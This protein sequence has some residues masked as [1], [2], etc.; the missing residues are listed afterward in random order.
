MRSRVRVSQACGSM[1]LSFAVVSSV[2]MVAQVRPPP[3]ERANRAFLRADGALD[4]VG[5]ELAAAIGEEAFQSGAP[6][7]GVADHLGGLG[8]ARDAR[9][10]AGRALEQLGND[11]RGHPIL[12]WGLL[13]LRRLAG[14]GRNLGLAVGGEEHVEALGQHVLHRA[15]LLGRK[16]L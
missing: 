11:R 6:R 8:P 15:P 7:Q 13:T 12:D 2:A 9:L 14:C 3:S 4:D 5:I 1:P 10:L 16:K